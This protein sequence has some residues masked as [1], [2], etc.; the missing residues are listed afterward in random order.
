MTIPTNWPLCTRF[1][2]VLKKDGFVIFSFLVL[3]LG[4]NSRMWYAPSYGAIEVCPS[5][6]PQKTCRCFDLLN[7]SC[8]DDPFAPIDAKSFAINAIRARTTA[9]CY[10][11]QTVGIGAGH[12]ATAM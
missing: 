9:G 7:V 1:L 5:D 11:L 2:L 10:K 4:T 3:Y 12:T 8:C 6:G